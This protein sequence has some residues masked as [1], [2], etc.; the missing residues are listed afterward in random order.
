MI[1][2][3]FLLA[4]L[5]VCAFG[6][7]D[8][9]TVRAVANPELVPGLIEVGAPFKI[10]IYMNNDD[11]EH[12]GYSMPFAFYSP[13]ASISNVVH[14]NV[15]AYGP[16]SSIELLNGWESLWVFLNEW[17]TFSWDGVL[18]DTINHSVAALNGW[19]P[20]SGDLVRIKFNYQ[21]DE[22]GSFCIDSVSIPNTSPPGKLDWLFD[23][24]TTFSGPY[25]WEVG[26]L[27]TDPEIGVDLDSLIF[28]SVQGESAPPAQVMHISNT[29]VGTLN[30]NASWNSSWLGVSPSHGTAPSIV[31]I[32]VNP[33]GLGVGVH[34]D[35]I[36]ISDPNAT[37]NPV[38]IPVRYTITE[39][40]PEILLSQTFFSFNAIA[41]STN[42]PDQFLTIYNDGGGSLSWTATNSESWLTLTPTSGGDGDQ[43]TLSV[44]ITGLAYNTYFDTVVITD[45]NASNS[46]QLAVVRLEV[47]SSLPILATDTS[48][49]VIPVDTDYP[50]PADRYFTIYNDGAG[51]MNYYLQTSS[52]RIASLTPDSGSVPQTVTIAFDSIAC[53]PGS[54]LFDTVY[55]YSLEALNSPQIVILQYNCSAAPPR[56]IISKDSVFAQIYECSQGT[57]SVI[58][59]SFTVYNDGSETFSYNL[60][61]NST[62]LLPSPV[63]AEEPKTIYL[64]FDYYGMVPGFYYDTVTVWAYNAI[65]NPQSIPIILQIKETDLPALI[66]VNKSQFSFVAQENRTD[67]DYWIRINNA[68][69]GCMEWD[70]EEDISWIEFG[71]DTTSDQRYPWFVRIMPN[72]YGI[73]MGHYYDTANVVSATASNSPFPITFDITVWKLRGDVNYN[74]VINILDVTY[75]MRYIYAGGPAPMPV[76]YVGDVNCDGFINVLDITLLFRYIYIDQSPLCG[77]PY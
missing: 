72:A 5:L 27:P 14:V 31:Q 40:P 21:I 71:I 60:T 1:R 43:I 35:T 32:Y 33:T 63:S 2:R 46:P 66:T 49:I 44:D 69:P 53:V 75:L 24:P 45:D 23:F 38:R 4:L 7:A 25:C 70:I 77:N 37:N 76:D 30:W 54:V 67:K 6:N 74:G 51:T 61:W 47:A 20:G 26:E 12:V 57:G 16:D 55:I 15:G 59:P 52:I 65:N 28:E 8:G 42:P 56:I 18:P 73:T 19:L 39:P 58:R 62:W 50:F 22:E 36:T 11:G 68:S 10:E 3:L 34:E 48:Y 41:D 64:D 9:T 13:D 17:T 29:G